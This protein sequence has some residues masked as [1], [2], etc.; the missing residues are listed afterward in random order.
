MLLEWLAQP[1]LPFFSS[2]PPKSSPSRHRHRQSFRTTIT[3]RTRARAALQNKERARPSVP[4]QL[5][6]QLNIFFGKKIKEPALC[7]DAWISPSP[8]C[9]RHLMSR[10]VYP[11]VHQRL[12]LKSPDE[13]SPSFAPSTNAK[14]G[15]RRWV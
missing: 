14:M 3:S 7:T 13:I 5:R 1:P 15:E 6:T 4:A 2:S 12:A 8:S 10:W 9:R 11:I